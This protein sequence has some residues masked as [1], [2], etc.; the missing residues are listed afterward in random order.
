MD[1]L[2]DLEARGARVY[3]GLIHALH[4][5]GG[6]QAQM[7]MVKQHIPDFGIAAPCGFGRGPGK[8]S[9]QDGL[10]TA[11]A[12]MDGLIAQHKKAVELLHDVRD[13]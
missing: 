1:P 2:G 12:Y 8:M 3:M 4:D 11:N 5:E 10:S 9:S 6:M 13:G 7:E